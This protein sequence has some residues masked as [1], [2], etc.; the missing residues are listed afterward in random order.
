MR[1]E[2]QYRGLGTAQPWGFGANNQPTMIGDSNYAY[3]SGSQLT[4]AVNLGTAVANQTGSDVAGAVAA[5]LSTAAAIVTPACPPC[6]AALALGAALTGIVTKMLQG[7]GQ[8]CIQATD[9]ANQAEPLL[10]QNLTNYVTAPVRYASLQQNALANFNVMFQNLVAA[11]QN[12]GG[13]GGAACI[14]DRQAGGCKW[15]ASPWKWNADGTF[16]PAGAAGSGNQCWNW[17]YGYHDAIAQD[18][19]VVPDPV[20]SA[21]GDVG[22]SIQNALSSLFGS[23]G[24][25]VASPSPLLL[26]AGGL[27]LFYLVSD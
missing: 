14:K 3:P 25:G 4:G 19:F 1:F 23:S 12:V 9:A 15:K 20:G 2:T 5:G 17:V 8:S 18:P 27:A 21:A 6:G 11:C 10:Q 16:T 22:S 26:I 24:G 13:A 7:C